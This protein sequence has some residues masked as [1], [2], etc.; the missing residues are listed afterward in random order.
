M[1]SSQGDH[2][3]FIKHSYIRKITTF[4]VYVDDIVAIEDDQEEIMGLKPY[5]AKEFEMKDLGKL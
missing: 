4:I 5:L 2:S 3:L 1:S